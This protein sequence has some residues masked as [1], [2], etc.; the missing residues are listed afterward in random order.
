M[1][2]N[3]GAEIFCRDQPP[4][5]AEEHCTAEHYL[6]VPD[7]QPFYLHMLSALMRDLGD[8]DWR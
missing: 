4:C 5:A 6:V 3:G 8:P 1:D 7:Y 2:R